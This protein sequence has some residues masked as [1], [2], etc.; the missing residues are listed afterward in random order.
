VSEFTFY[1]V[2]SNDVNRIVRWGSRPVTGA[3]GKTEDEYVVQVLE[4]R[5]PGLWESHSM[6][7]TAD[8]FHKLR[9]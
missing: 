6:I 2:L 1:D 8:E 9:Q 4:R 5:D 3:N 7:L